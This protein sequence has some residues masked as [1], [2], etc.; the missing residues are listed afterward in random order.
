MTHAS[1][2]VLA[3][4]DEIDAELKFA[5][6]A[7]DNNDPAAGLPT[8]VGRGKNARRVWKVT[9]PAGHTMVVSRF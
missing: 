4:S 5:N 2:P 3:F 6:D 1:L 7:I 9:M 8:I